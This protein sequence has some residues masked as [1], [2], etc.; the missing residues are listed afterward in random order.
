MEKNVNEKK[1]YN[2]KFYLKNYVNMDRCYVI[3]IRLYMFDTGIYESV[4]S[5]I[6]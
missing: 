4:G 1:I 5:D 3:R 6:F 2:R